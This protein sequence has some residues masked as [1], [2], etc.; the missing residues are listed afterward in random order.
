LLRDV[1]S[2]AEVETPD[3]TFEAVANGHGIVLLAEGNTTVYARPGI[4]YRSVIDL[5]PC[6]LAIAWRRR[7]KR[8]A[9]RELVNAALEA[10]QQDELT[11]AREVG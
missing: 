6:Q 9:I 4:T 10:A 3:E 1:V 11:T 5:T 7:D 8:P 2:G